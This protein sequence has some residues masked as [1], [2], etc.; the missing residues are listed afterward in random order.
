MVDTENFN[1]RCPLCRED[2][3]AWLFIHYFDVEGKISEM[4]DDCIDNYIHLNAP[5]VSCL[6]VLEW[7]DVITDLPSITIEQSFG[8]YC[9]D[10]PRKTEYF[11]ITADIITN[12]VVMD[13]LIEKEFNPCRNHVFLEGIHKKEN[14]YWELMFGS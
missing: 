10:T 11:T 4:G 14:G 13:H 6:S 7:D 5:F 8:C 9:Y 12:K 1:F 2:W 3:T